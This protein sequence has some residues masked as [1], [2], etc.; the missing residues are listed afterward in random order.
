[1]SAFFRLY[2]DKGTLTV[3]TSA[4]AIGVSKKEFIFCTSAKR[5]IGTKRLMEFIVIVA[6]GPEG[7][8][9]VP[10]DRGHGRRGACR[11]RPSSRAKSLK[12]GEIT[13]FPRS[14][15]KIAE[16]EPEYPHGHGENF[17]VVRRGRQ[18]PRESRSSCHMDG[19]E[20]KVEGHAH[21]MAP[22]VW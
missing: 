14:G 10:L 6:P 18:E 21:E 15:G 3:T 1:M 16:V 22:S 2:F 4:Q 9:S 19:H 11:A 8:G 12:N 13:A 17:A 5:D 20:S 7:S